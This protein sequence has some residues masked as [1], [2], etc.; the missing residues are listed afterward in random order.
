M[1]IDQFYI[2]DFPITEAENNSPVGL[3]RYAS[4]TF[5]IA[6]QR[7]QAVAVQP[8]IINALCYVKTC[9]DRS[10]PG[11]HIGRQQAGITILNWPEVFGYFSIHAQGKHHVLASLPL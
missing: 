9:K 7:M 10:Y 4:V 6:F 11:K 5:Q 8:E 3:D 1:I 2:K